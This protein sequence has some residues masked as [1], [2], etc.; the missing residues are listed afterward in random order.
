MGVTEFWT[1][2]LGDFKAQEYRLLSSLPVK[3]VA[4]DTSSWIHKFDAD[5]EVSYARTSDPKYVHPRIILTIADKVKAL[6]A[7]GI[8]PI[9]VLDGKAPCVK[10]KT[11][12]ERQNKSEKATREYN[13]LV[14][15][16][17][18]TSPTE[19]IRTRALKLRKEKA[20]PIPHEFAALV[21]WCCKNNVDYVQAPFEA[22]AQMKQLM[23]CGKAD[24]V[25][26]EDGD[27]VIFGASHLLWKVSI[28]ILEPRQSK[29]KYFDLQALK[30]GD[31]NSE[32]AAGR[33]TDFLPEISC[34]SG[35][36]YISNIPKVGPAKI[37]SCHTIKKVKRKALIDSFIEDTVTNATKSEHQWLQEYHADYHNTKNNNTNNPPGDWS[38][39]KFIKVRN[40]IRH[41]PVFERNAETGEVTLVPLNPLPNNVPNA[42]WGDYIGFD[43]HPAAYFEQSYETYYDMT[44]VSSANLPRN[45]LLN[46]PRYIDTDN[47]EV[48]SSKVLPLFGRINFEQ[49]P[50]ELQP[51]VVLGFYLLARG[52]VYPQDVSLEQMQAMTRAAAEAG[53]NRPVLDPD[54]VPKPVKWVGFEP[55]DEVEIG[56]EYD[57][58]VSS[59]RQLWY[60][61]AV[62]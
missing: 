14:L 33:R 20:R 12:R 42:E 17:Q 61:C 8:K 39:D 34:L 28:N 60:I 26:A 36:D 1:K 52:V 5:S 53:I 38:P 47:P 51:K 19:P 45:T 2:C 27:L 56:N 59:F 18:F 44:V 54:L 25:M 13:A 57:D 7:L 43:S 21:E 48:E 50:I 10:Q 15:Q 4:I 24:A 31:Y 46:H 29:C 41:Y 58:W 40:L 49:D 37:L 16:T 9:F 35:N 32:L 3:T 23:M 6:K 11:N 62:S 55:L 22:D 30:D